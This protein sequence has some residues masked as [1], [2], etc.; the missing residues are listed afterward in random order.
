[1]NGSDRFWTCLYT[2]K[3]KYRQASKSRQVCAIYGP[4]FSLKIGSRKRFQLQKRLV[5]IPNFLRIRLL[6]MMNLE[7]EI[8]CHLWRNIDETCFWSINSEYVVFYRFSHLFT[9]AVAQK[10]NI[11]KEIN[12]IVNPKLVETILD[13]RK[14]PKRGEV[15]RSIFRRQ[16][17][18]TRSGG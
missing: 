7:F 2:C 8:A 17:S 1:M 6:D 16:T 3:S 5:G 4:I 9:T 13:I 12:F 18:C 15:F 10:Q 14:I 11:W